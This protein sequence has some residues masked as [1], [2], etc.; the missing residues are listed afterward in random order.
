MKELATSWLADQIIELEEKLRLKKIDINNFSDK[1][2][3]L[4][5][6]AIDMEKNNL[7]DFVL[8]YLIFGKYGTKPM[9]MKELKIDIK[10]YYEQL[11][12]SE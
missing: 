3:L 9:N 1:K 5:E 10:D 8:N 6:L 12:K 11:Y 2:D 7:I 4:I